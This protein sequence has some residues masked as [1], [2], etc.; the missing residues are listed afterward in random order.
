VACRNVFPKASLTG[1]IDD[2][3]VVSRL[4][5]IIE[6][7]NMARIARAHQNGSFPEVEGPN[8][9]RIDSTRHGNLKIAHHIFRPAEDD[10]RILFGL[11][12]PVRCRS[13]NDIYLHVILL[14]ESRRCVLHRRKRS[15]W[16]INI[17]YSSVFIGRRSGGSRL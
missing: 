4:E 13:A 7:L 8:R 17:Q 9:R 1:S 5:K 15:S 12:K 2:K 3:D 10:V 6:S 11:R 16:P 14:A